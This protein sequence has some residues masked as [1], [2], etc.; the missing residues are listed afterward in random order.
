V[1]I[2]TSTL[3][4]LVALAIACGGRPTV[5]T[6][7]SLEALRSR[8]AA[9]P[10]DLELQ[11]TLVVAEALANEGD[12]RVALT[13]LSRGTGLPSDRA[14]LV[15]LH[16]LLN[17]VTGNP[18][19]AYDNYARALQI[20]H[21]SADLT[22]LRITEVAVA[23]IAGL[24]DAVEHYNER[25][26]TLLEPLVDGTNLHSPARHAALN[27]LQSLAQ[28]RGDVADSRK[29]TALEGCIT[30]F[31]VAGP[32]GPHALMGFDE[33]FA[34]ETDSTFAENYDLGPR[35]G[36]RPT[37][38]ALGDGCT[39]NLGSGP[40]TE[41][42]VSYGQGTFQ[43]ATS[44]LFVMRVSTPNS[45]E[46]FV[47]GSSV[48]RID[49]RKRATAG[50]LYIPVELAAGAHRIT[51]K[52]ASRHSNPAIA[53][54][55]TAAHDNDLV[56]IDSRA[57]GPARTDF[58]DAFQT[59]LQA[60]V[61]FQRDD[62]VAAREALIHLDGTHQESPLLLMQAA[63]AWFSDPL[64][65]S[66]VRMD[67]GRLLLEAS[68]R[69]WPD[70]WSPTLHL[71]T[72][73]ANN[74][75]VTEAI[76][77][78][79][80]ATRRFPKVPS[81]PLSLIELLN[82]HEWFAEADQVLA[83]LVERFPGLC[84]SNDAA[85][86][87]ARR[88]L[89]A[90]DAIAITEQIMQCNA[91]SNARYTALLRQRKVGEARAELERLTQLDQTASTSFGILRTQ[92]D[93]ALELAEADT[94][95]AQLEQLQK[96]FPRASGIVME[97]MDRALQN[98]DSV[99]AL[100]IL[101]AATRSETAAMSDLRRVE[102]VLR[103]AH[104]M[105]PH[106]VDGLRVIADFEQ[107]GHTYDGPQVLVWDYM[108]VRVFPDGSALKLVHSIQRVQ[109]DEAA[110]ELG[111]VSIPDDARVLTLRTVKADKRVLEPDAIS[112]K[113]T[114]S[115]PTVT[116]G[117]YTE[118]E[119]LI[120]DDPSSAFP[121]GYVGDRFYFRS[122]EV[123]FET[124]Q[125]IMV[126]P[127]D[128]A[129]TVDGRG[130]APV[131]TETTQGTERVLSWKVTQSRPV[132]P[133]ALAVAHREYVPSVRVVAKAPW[134]DLVSSLRDA[135]LDKDIQ[136]PEIVRLVASIV[137]E[138]SPDDHAMRAERLYHW[139]LANVE[140]DSQLFGQAAVMLRARSGNRARVLHHL[141]SL[142]G[143]PSQI[144]LVRSKG[145]D[146]TISDLADPDTY[147][148]AV[149]RVG[150]TAPTWLSTVDRWAPYGYLPP[151]LRG[152]DAIMLGEGGEI[153][154][155]RAS[156]EGE[157]RRSTTMDITVTANGS[158]TFEV[159]E[160]FRGAEATGWREA[161]EGTAPAELERRFEAS[162]VTTLVPGARL[163]SLRMTG[164][165]GTA[166]SLVL[167]YSFEVSQLGRRVAQGWALPAVVPAR[168]SS[169]FATVA[170]RTTT[171]ILTP[172]VDTDI[173]LRFHLPEQRTAPHLQPGQELHG[174][175]G[176][177]FILRSEW[178]DGV[179]ALHRKVRVPMV[180][181]PPKLYP[182]LT[183]F[184]RKVDEIENAETLIQL[185]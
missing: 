61:S 65:P 81:I 146:A 80:E 133:E 88:K 79:R 69:R 98:G 185:Q 41:G 176:T 153:V 75:R 104:V 118:V 47:D 30:Q 19:H 155:V 70:L 35:R 177:L 134:S 119:Y 178:T 132:P 85:M 7:P 8:A 16:G 183:E 38:E 46:V 168:L 97:R 48:V 127:A 58:D 136:D 76:E 175:A 90:R 135:L 140:D 32:F 123:P 142:A 66:D 95:N 64:T 163:K 147:A 125:L 109:S 167:Q 55:L 14:D 28:R 111:E 82:D 130:D 112:G 170:R 2:R 27:L 67:R 23:G 25:T 11:A 162:Y 86:F 150:G 143:V 152:Q 148:F 160:H 141:L 18:D 115:L 171:E 182:A 96:R 91:R 108:V 34:P 156:E 129:I 59:Y 99:T 110:D 50:T 49:R 117:D 4:L 68:V 159:V 74:G 94:A 100:S 139:V 92:I 107:S 102:G 52:V 44:T 145:A 122:F 21:R 184:C 31:Q 71:A 114:V 72:I 169:R 22:S 154:H 105:D 62:A 158:A 166:A 37:R 180:R 137:G 113:D 5:P 149:V 42:G 57:A 121:H 179:L 60:T 103:G 40:V 63:H 15:F 56:A 157:D 43:A 173:T 89:R 33:T 45:A 124:S 165:E 10:S 181:V 83:A 6:R 144:A 17:E 84:G 131:A 126:L 138:A 116:A 151:A 39:V 36:V 20:A 29:L 174:P 164:R 24:F 101:D 9:A 51:V 77:A 54:A 1:T 26:R 87:S 53:V 3:I 172:P 12:P 128:M 78:L 120:A 73:E 161:L 13:A 106:R 93:L